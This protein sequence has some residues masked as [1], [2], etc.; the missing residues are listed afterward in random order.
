MPA[1]MREINTRY[2]VDGFYMNGWPMFNLPVCYCAIC[3]KLP[4][5]KTPAYWRNSTDRVIGAVE[6][7]RRDRKGEERGGILF[8]EYGRRNPCDAESGPGGRGGAVVPGR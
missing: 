7:V 5:A 6:A 8:R 4:P 1:I 2:D 3:R